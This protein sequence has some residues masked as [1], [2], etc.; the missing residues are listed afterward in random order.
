MRADVNDLAAFG[1]EQEQVRVA[2]KLAELPRNDPAAVRG[3]VAGRAETAELERPLVP[4]IEPPHDDVEVDSVA[5]VR[6]VREQRA[7]VRDMRRVVDV[8]RI[9]DERLA[10]QVQ[11]RPL[12][13]ALVDL[14]QEPIVRK[15]LA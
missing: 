10:F 2:G 9:H 12:V 7:V 6:R 3:E 11:L 13:P 5:P 8:P 14:E 1:A 15:Q 4:A